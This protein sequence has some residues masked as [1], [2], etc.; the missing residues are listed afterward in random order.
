MG[1]NEK[2]K[3]H[4]FIQLTRNLKVSLQWWQFLG[5]IFHK[6][7]MQPGCN[8]DKFPV[9]EP[10]AA[11]YTG[12]LNGGISL[13]TIRLEGGTRMKT[14]LLTDLYLIA[15]PWLKQII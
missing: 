9:Q 1:S 11:G 3:N 7:G 2:R 10:S 12:S 4:Q 15:F 5:G 6:T 8:G 13:R 14:G